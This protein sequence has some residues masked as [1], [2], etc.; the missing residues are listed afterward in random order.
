MRDRFHRALL[1][2]QRW[3]HA[4]KSARLAALEREVWEEL[5]GRS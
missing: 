1:R 4:R 3:A 2:Y 5:R